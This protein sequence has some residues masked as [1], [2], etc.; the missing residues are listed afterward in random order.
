MLKSLSLAALMALALTVP[1]LAEANAVYQ[2]K[3]CAADATG[4][5][6]RHINQ[7]Y[8]E[9][10]G[11]NPESMKINTPFVLYGK[12]HTLAESPGLTLWKFC[13]NKC[14]R[15]AT[16]YAAEAQA[17]LAAR[18]TPILSDQPQ[19][20]LNTATGGAVQD[21]GVE[22]LNKKLDGIIMWGSIAFGIL[23]LIS[24]SL[25]ALAIHLRAKS[26]KRQLQEAV[27]AKNTAEEMT[28]TAL[29][30]WKAL[31]DERAG[32][33]PPGGLEETMSA[34][35]E[36]SQIPEVLADSMICPSLPPMEHWYVIS[37]EC[38]APDSRNSAFQ[39]FVTATDHTALDVR[40]RKSK[41][42]TIL[43]G[44]P[45]WA[46]DPDSG[47][48]RFKGDPLDVYLVEYGSNKVQR[49]A[50][51]LVRQLSSLFNDH[52]DPSI[53]KWADRRGIKLNETVPLRLIGPYPSDPN[54]PMHP[55]YLE[56]QLVAVAG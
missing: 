4:D 34:K 48:Q 11:L 50:A 33:K 45:E 49:I 40:Q 17:A 36:P 23:V 13:E 10:P 47:S 32:L 5:T 7:I 55:E 41:I 38:V 2:I 51:G 42:R 18:P 39:V 6:C 20:Q 35:S 16:E 29:H 27:E 25:A 8:K 15:L 44:Y 21:N 37:P 12:K 24:I 53:K 28:R 46:F 3:N 56:K 31:S 43:R 9:N 26:W 30:A 22:K 14:S 54:H 1:A 19:P 52:G